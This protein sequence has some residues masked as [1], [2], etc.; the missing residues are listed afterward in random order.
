MCFLYRIA[1][2]RKKKRLSC[3]SFCICSLTE[4][5]GNMD[6][7]EVLFSIFGS[8]REFFRRILRSRPRRMM[9]SDLAI[10]R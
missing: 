10:V 1:V 7:M 4:S 3:N 9:M 6:K 8:I 5:N 2:S